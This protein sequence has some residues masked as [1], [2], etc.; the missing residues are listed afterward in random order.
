MFNWDKT[1]GGA[2]GRGMI[3]GGG[4]GGESREGF[5]RRPEMQP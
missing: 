3:V 5:V 2:R 1:T 4:P